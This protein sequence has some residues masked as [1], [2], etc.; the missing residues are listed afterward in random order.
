MPDIILSKENYQVIVARLGF[1]GNGGVPRILM[2]GM[3]EDEMQIQEIPFT[4]GKGLL[5]QF[6]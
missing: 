2:S 1:F 6:G 5:L 4:L 3:G